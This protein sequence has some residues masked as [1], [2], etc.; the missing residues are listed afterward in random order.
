MLGNDAVPRPTLRG[1]ALL[2]E[3]LA[4]GRGRL[5]VEAD[6]APFVREGRSVFSKFVVTADPALSPGSSALIVDPD[7]QLLAVGRL[8]LAPHEM[9]RLQRGIAAWVTSHGGSRAT[10]D[11]HED[12]APS[13]DP[14]LDDGL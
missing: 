5:T 3:A 9:R 13:A 14:A 4:P 2:H 10:D 12:D 1:A 11:D 8:L 7:D 6:A